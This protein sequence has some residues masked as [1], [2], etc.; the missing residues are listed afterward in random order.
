MLSPLR[1]KDKE[2]DPLSHKNNKMMISNQ[3]NHIPVNNP[4]LY[5]IHLFRAKEQRRVFLCLSWISRSKQLN[6]NRKRLILRNILP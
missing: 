3:L 6:K 1:K 5:H 2:R 4:A